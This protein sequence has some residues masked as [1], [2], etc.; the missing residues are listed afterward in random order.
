MRTKG[1]LYIT[2]RLICGYCENQN[3]QTFEGFPGCHEVMPSTPPG[4]HWLDGVAVCDRHVIKLDDK[5][6]Q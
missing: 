5:E 2:H 3:A 6:A 1:A 4:W